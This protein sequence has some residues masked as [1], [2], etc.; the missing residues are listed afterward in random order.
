MSGNVAHLPPLWWVARRSVRLLTCLAIAVLALSAWSPQQPTGA[1]VADSAPYATVLP[2]PADV[3]HSPAARPAQPTH[4]P[5]VAAA[6]ASG[7]SA[8]GTAASGTAASDAATGGATATAG[9]TVGNRQPVEAGR[10]RPGAADVA[11]DV[12]AVSGAAARP[13]GPRAPPHPLA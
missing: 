4:A 9:D 8:S 1:P 13:A 10:G 12:A 11:A 3:R 2:V 7:T 6:S 5:T